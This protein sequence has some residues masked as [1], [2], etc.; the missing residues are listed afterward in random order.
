MALLQ[1]YFRL[2]S[3]TNHH[4][5][6]DVSDNLTKLKQNDRKMKKSTYEGLSDV[7]AENFEIA[8]ILILLLAV[9]N[10]STYIALLYAN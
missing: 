8:R 10:A 7:L 2:L 4:I 6:P 3:T 1:Q 5:Y 9:R